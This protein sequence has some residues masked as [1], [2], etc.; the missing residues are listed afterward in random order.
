MAH[1]IVD[2][3]TGGKCNSLLSV[4]FLLKHLSRFFHDQIVTKF[5]DINDTFAC[6]TLG[7]ALLEYAYKRGENNASGKGGKRCE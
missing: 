5:A 1:A 7:K 3:D 6:D 4:L 2:R